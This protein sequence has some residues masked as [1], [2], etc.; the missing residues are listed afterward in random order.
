LPLFTSS[1]Y[2]SDNFEPE[3]ETPEPEVEPE[4]AQ[5]EV[6]EIVETVCQTD[7]SREIA[8][9]AAVVQSVLLPEALPESPTP[10]PSPMAASAAA[11]PEVVAPQVRAAES[12]PR[13]S[14][15]AS[16]RPAAGQPVDIKEFWRSLML[17]VRER[18]K[19][20]HAVLTDAK[21]TAV[22]EQRFE[23]ALP[24]G[25][26]WHR[27]KLQEG[28][29]LLEAVACELA[30]GRTLSMECTLGGEKVTPPKDTE[31]DDLV[32]RASGVFGGASIVE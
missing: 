29:K 11:R 20:L 4:V 32:A 31:H 10:E 26:E 18:D 17:T 9:A 25:F 22:E 19:R 28:R 7:S 24:T 5:V 14:Q 6:L 8:Q 15:A 27:D 16:S 2:G 30:G 13:A 3:P 12:V 21:L 23:I 1:S